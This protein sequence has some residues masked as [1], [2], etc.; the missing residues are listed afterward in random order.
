MLQNDI[1]KLI[2]NKMYYFHKREKL[3]ENY[4]YAAFTVSS[5]N[6]RPVYWP[7][8][9][10]GEKRTVVRQLLSPR[11]PYTCYSSDIVV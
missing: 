2:H 4:T 11:G 9:A 10:R 6:Q 5:F 7:G 1:I 3:L 8:Q